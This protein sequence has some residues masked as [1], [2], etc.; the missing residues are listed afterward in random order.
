MRIIAAVSLAVV[1]VLVAF[2]RGGRKDAESAL[3]RA[4]VVFVALAGVWLLGYPELAPA[5]FPSWGI[6]A[7]PSLFVVAVI[8]LLMQLYK[9]RRQRDR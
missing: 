9:V 4:I 8:W 6:Y 7:L 2:I 3:V 1:C 5:Y